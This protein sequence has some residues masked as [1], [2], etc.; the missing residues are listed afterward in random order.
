MTPKQLAATNKAIKTLGGLTKTA[1]RYGISVPAVQ[2][3]RTRGVPKTRV[4]E[5]GQ[6]SGVAL[7]LLLP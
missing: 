4:K 2:N 7:E 1:K 5:V 6:D 3:W